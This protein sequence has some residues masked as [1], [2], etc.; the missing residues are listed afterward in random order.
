MNKKLFVGFGLT[1]LVGMAHAQMMTFTVVGDRLQY[2]NVATVESNT[3]FET[4]TGRSSAVS[5]T[6]K[7]DP[8]KKTGSGKIMI[9]MKSIDTG[10]PS[11][12][13]HMNGE[14]WL[15]TTKY[16]TATFETT[17]VKFVK[18]EDYRATGKFTMRGVTKTMTVPVKV[19]Y[20]AASEAVTKAGFAGNVVQIIA[21]FDIKLSDFG[22]K[23]PAVAEGK[24]S[25]NVS[26]NVSAYATTK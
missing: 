19:R 10:I 9:D 11:R 14:M 24:V 25:N 22:V 3:E 12:N 17:S 4:F 26:L 6:L 20:R 15:N 13:D 21:K 16:P 7:F 23:I 2:R 1:A 8:T 5:G 18:G